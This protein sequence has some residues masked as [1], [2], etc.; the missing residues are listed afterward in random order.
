MYEKNKKIASGMIFSGLVAV[1]LSS[2]GFSLNDNEIC[3]INYSI[4]RLKE[5]N[6]QISYISVENPQYNEN[7]NKIK[8]LRDKEN[9]HKQYTRFRNLFL[10]GGISLSGGIGLY[11][12]NKK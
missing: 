4:K 12:L 11:L 8:E 6:E 9:I 5:H 1:V 2:V 10:A 7:I 3:K